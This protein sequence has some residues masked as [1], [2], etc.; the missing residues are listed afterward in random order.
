[1]NEPGQNMSP[2]RLRAA[3]EAGELTKPRYI[4]AMH[5]LHS[6][7]HEYAAYLP[8][9]DIGRIEIGDGEVVMTTRSNGLRFVV[10]PIDQRTTPVETLNFGR[11]EGAQGD[12]M[13]ALIADGDV[14]FDVGAN[15]GYYSMRIARERLHSTIHAFEPIPQTFALLQRHLSLNSIANVHAQ[16]LGLSDRTGDLIFYF[17]PEGSGN[18]SA[19]NVSGRSDVQRITS[20]V[21]P[22]D[23]VA[24]RLGT[25]VDFVK[26]DVEGAELF[27]LR[28]A[29]ATLRHDRPA[30][31][32]ELLR[33][34]AAPFG[35]HPNDVLDLLRGFGYLAFV[36]D[37]AGRLAPF[38]RV[39]DTTV[40]TNYIFFHPERHG[41]LIERFVARG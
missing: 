20:R 27:T 29:A 38:G 4:E 32:V 7:L 16:N 10:D 33:K 15:V 17:Y 11:Y 28:G 25:R 30:L 26:C 8:T 19:A 37:S 1:M 34:W 18:A 6:I 23:A 41:P 13:L 39:D 14:V 36:V 2:G 21:E 35:Y 31:F 40:E 22:L 24:S 12:M 5:G 3:F 9:T